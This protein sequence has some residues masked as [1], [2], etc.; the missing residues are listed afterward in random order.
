MP[1]WD[2]VG[3]SFGI[4]WRHKYLWL[5]GLFAAEGGGGS[6]FSYN[7]GTRS[8]GT[9]GSPSAVAQ[10]VS[11]WSSQHAA[12]L[13]TLAVLWIILAIGLFILAAVCEGA[14][15][16]AAAEHD[17]DRPFGLREAWTTGV[18]TMWL[19]V[20]F[21][22]LLLVLVIPAVVI[23]VAVIVGG[24]LAA[25]ANAGT[26]AVTLISLG[27]LLGLALVVYLIYLSFLDRF[28]A[29]AAILEQRGAVASLGRAH[30]LLIARFGRSLL[31]WLVAIA[32]TIGVGIA[33]AVV[34]LVAAVPLMVAT[35]AA[36][37]GAP[38]AWP[39]I[40]LGGVVLLAV[41]L[42]IAGFLGAQASTYWT[43]SFRRMEID[44]PPAYAYP[45]APA[46]QPPAS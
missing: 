19:I 27:A 22:L 29:R 25:F 36:F 21:R 1:Y 8:T 41:A 28:G 13:V 11:Q 16:R 2:N 23:V 37:N 42:P 43:V 32:V 6:N 46:P 7:Q 18:R 20:R 12:L 10:Q 17:A 34:F 14:L 40:V 3:R 35:I 24:V 5:L 9:T 44:Y 39:F 38:A 31:V 33:V 4:A 15:I 45:V 30:R 26:L